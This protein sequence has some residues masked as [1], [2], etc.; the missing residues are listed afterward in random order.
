MTG[1][2]IET[3]WDAVQSSDPAFD[4]VFLYGVKS[5]GIVCR[6]SCRSRVPGRKN[7]IFFTDLQEALSQ[8]FR[9]C[10][11]CR[12]DLRG[13]YDPAGETLLEVEKILQSRYAEPDIQ[14]ALPSLVGLSRAHLDRIFKARRGRSLSRTLAFIRV[15]KAR[16]F[17]AD[18]RK[19]VTRIAMETG[20]SSL[21]CFYAAF[22]EIMGKSPG[23]CR[24]GRPVRQADPAFVTYDVVQVEDWTLTVG[25]RGSVLCKVAV[26]AGDWEVFSSLYSCRRDPAAC[27]DAVGQLREYF[28]GKRKTFSLQLDLHGTPFSRRVWEKLRDI[29]YGETRSYGQVAL[30]LDMPRA[31]RAIGQAGARN[32]VPVVIPCHR[33]IGGDGRL[34]GYKGS[35]TAFKRFLIDLE[36]RNSG[37]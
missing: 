6:P 17:L 25:T 2:A 36:R 1:P 13:A 21:S 10:K 9:P 28:R 32:P 29:P 20:F 4:G 23:T 22:R 31:A 8:G 5:T 11:R 30:A 18:S 14:E 19:S 33:V 3:M 37:R 7:V 26:D 16:Q 27:F 35:N 24:R 34:T 12:P 15:E